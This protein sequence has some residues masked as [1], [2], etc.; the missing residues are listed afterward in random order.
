[1]EGGRMRGKDFKVFLKQKWNAQH[2]YWDD[3]HE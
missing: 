1:M 2:D 3:K